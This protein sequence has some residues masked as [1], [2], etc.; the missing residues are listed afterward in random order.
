[1]AHLIHRATQLKIPITTSTTLTE[2]NSA[3]AKLKSSILAIHKESIKQRQ[4]HVLDL[5]KISEDKGDDK[6]ATIL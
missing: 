4:E 6:K 3:I 1:M 2:A 5:A